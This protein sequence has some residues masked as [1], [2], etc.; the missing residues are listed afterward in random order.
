MLDTHHSGHHGKSIPSLILEVAMIV[1][2]VFLGLAAEQWREGRHE[3]DLALASLRNFR[4]EIITNQGQIKRVR[5]YHQALAQNLQNFTQEKGPH[6]FRRFL[7]DVQFR[8]METVQLEHTA[9]DLALATQALTYMKPDMAY[10]ISRLYTQQQSFQTIENSFM[11]SAFTPS[12]FADTSSTVGLT[13]AMMAYMGDVNIQEPGLLKAY[14]VV[15]PKL[16]SALDNHAAAHAASATPGPDSS[17]IPKS[18]R[19]Q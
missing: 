4:T 6:T 7:T 9:W 3:H 8:G 15:L 17:T 2:G 16:D 19:S 13:I 10:T 12:T 18:Q 5:A 14:A 1:V 11:Q